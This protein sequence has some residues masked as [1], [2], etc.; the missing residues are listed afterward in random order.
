MLVIGNP[1]PKRDYGFGVAFRAVPRQWR[2]SMS[3]PGSVHI[4]ELVRKL[5]RIATA[6]RW[7]IISTID[8]NDY[9]RKKDFAR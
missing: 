5:Y 3:L 2:M 9:V 8:H 7:P 6:R 4:S 1:D